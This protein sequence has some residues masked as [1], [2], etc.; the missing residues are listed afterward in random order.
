MAKI[1]S[2]ACMSNLFMMAKMLKNRLSKG[3][4][5]LNENGNKNDGQP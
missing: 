5:H 1:G 3:N 2:K 4:N